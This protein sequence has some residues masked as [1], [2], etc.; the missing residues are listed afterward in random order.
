MTRPLTNINGW[1]RF[2][3]M[4]ELIKRLEKMGHDGF[5]ISI[6]YG[7]SAGHGWLYTVEILT[8]DF[9]SFDNPIAANSFNECID[10]AEK[11]IKERGW[12]IN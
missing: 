5:S 3:I 10:I 7:P 9:K 6:C 11:E 1:G 8:P 4:L 2:G 12:S